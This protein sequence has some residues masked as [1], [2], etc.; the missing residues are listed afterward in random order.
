MPSVPRTGIST[1]HGRDECRWA[2]RVNV[3]YADRGR[4][5]LC[6][7]SLAL[8]A[9]RIRLSSSTKHA[10][11][12]TASLRAVFG[13]SSRNR[14]FPSARPP[15]IAAPPI[16]SGGLSRSVVFWF[17]MRARGSADGGLRTSGIK[18]SLG[19]VAMHVLPERTRVC[20][21]RSQVGINDET[22]LCL[23][24]FCREDHRLVWLRCGDATT[25]CRLDRAKARRDTIR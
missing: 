12:E 23:S 17:L 19:A 7:V 13:T 20:Y 21:L 14:R 6:E 9:M 10:L 5:G 25:E 3:S 24:Q 8:R 16:P 2:A 4:C 18:R 1:P 22:H 15:K 11:D